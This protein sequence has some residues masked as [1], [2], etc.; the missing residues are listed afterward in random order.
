MDIDVDEHLLPRDR[1]SYHCYMTSVPHTTTENVTQPAFATLL[2]MRLEENVT[3]ADIVTLPSPWG[4]PLV[5][6]ACGSNS[7]AEPILVLVNEA[8]VNFIRPTQ[9][10][11][12]PDKWQLELLH[13]QRACVDGRLATGSDLFHAIEKGDDPPDATVYIGEQKSGW[14]LTT[15][16]IENRRLAHDLFMRVRTK[17][18]FQQRHRVTHLA[19]HIIYM[20][21]GLAGRGTG[22][23]YRRNDDAAVDQL[24]EA[25]QHYQADPTHYIVDAKAGPPA[26]LAAGFDAVNA[27]GDVAFFCTP[28]VNAVPTSPLFS[29]TGLE[30]GLAYQSLHSAP[31][32]WKRL[33]A[34]VHRKDRPGN[35]TLLISAGAPDRFGNQYPA[36]E[37]LANFLLDHPEPIASDHLS[38]VILHFWSSGRA[39]NLLGDRPQQLW[40][41]VYQGTS[42]AFQP[43]A[44]SPA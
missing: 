25:I 35:H 13:L 42:P 18:A 39:V 44:A 22:L 8:P 11:D 15:F 31:A 41:P 24:I 43:F 37:V 14:E 36:E 1:V 4:A 29:L 3:I 12:E 7:I 16:S 32:E 9:P 10:L 30:I 21:F 17:L 34:S 23:P 19:G 6:G 5:M 33:R 27:P 20:W 28:F 26:Q 2:P 38:S 40:R